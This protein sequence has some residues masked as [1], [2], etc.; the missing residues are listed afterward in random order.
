MR[1]GRRGLGNQVDGIERRIRHKS[2]ALDNLSDLGN[3]RLFMQ[4][5]LQPELLDS[6]PHD[7]PDAL[8]NRR[9]LRITNHVLGHYRW[10]ARTLRRHATPGD[11]VLE[12]GAGT[13]EL[14]AYLAARGHSTDGLDLWPRPPSWAPECEWHRADLLKFERYAD[15]AVI[16]GNLILHQ[17]NS[18]QLAA[19]GEKIRPTA[20]LILA[21][22]P[23]RRRASQTLFAALGPLLGANHV[24][25]HD[26]HVS[27][28]AGFQADELP[29]LLGLNRPEWTYRCQP[30]LLGSYRM[31][32]W[33]A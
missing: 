18:E 2:G 12:L 11:R 19:L 20:R 28:A 22:E 21:C 32:A 17:F 7:H 25:L 24:S 27:I 33:R 23:L 29:Q 14:G 15:Y 6:L 10:F 13:G 4:R 3:L 5:K 16:T 8:H 30:T 9:D 1:K 26:A 31:M